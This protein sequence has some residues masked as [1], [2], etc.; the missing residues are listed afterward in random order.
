MLMVKKIGGCLNENEMVRSGQSQR[1]NF[2]GAAN[3]E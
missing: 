1:E 3:F 2:G